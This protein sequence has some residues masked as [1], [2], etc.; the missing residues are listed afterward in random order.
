MAFRILLVDDETGILNAWTRALQSSGYIVKTAQT[1]KAA[2]ELCEEY[3]FDV[4]VL[5]YIMPTMKGLELLTRI[6][7]IQPL[8]RSILVSGKLDTGY[9]DATL[10]TE[11]RE[12]VEADDYLHKPVS[13]QKLRESI[14]SLLADSSSTEWKS[15]ASKTLKSKAVTIEKAK[16]ATKR[17]DTIRKKR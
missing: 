1:A 5:D 9:D 4:V 13:N 14:Q 10:A 17:L 3:A 8:I 11:L 16:A 2:I 15:L 6:R 12:S 7:K